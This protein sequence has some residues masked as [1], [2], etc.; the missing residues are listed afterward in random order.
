MSRP[1]AYRRGPDRP[2]DDDG[3]RAS[4]G[5]TLFMKRCKAGATMI[6][7]KTSLPFKILVPLCSLLILC[8]WKVGQG[9]SQMNRRLEDMWTISHQEEWARQMRRGNTEL[10]VPDAREIF[11]NEPNKPIN[12]VS[13]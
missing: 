1:E 4:F 10:T 9:F 12:L 5:D 3:A 6:N 11:K 13:H 8:T 7:E 2:E